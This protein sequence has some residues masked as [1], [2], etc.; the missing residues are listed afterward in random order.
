MPDADPL[1]PL[2]RL[3]GVPSAFAAARDGIDALLR[4]RGLRRTSSDQTA[5]ALLV[6][7]H[8]SAVLEG[9]TSTLDE[10]RAGTG[11]DL[12][13]DAVRVSV[14]LLSLVP[15]LRT[16]PL[17]A[18]ARLHALASGGAESGRPARRRVPG[19]PAGPRPAAGR[20]DRGAS[21]ARGGRG[22][23]RPRDG[24]ALPVPQRHRRPGRRA[25]G[26]GSPAA[27]TSA[28]CWCRK[29]GTSR[30]GRRTSRTC[31]GTAT[32][33]RP[34]WLLAEVRSR[35]GRQGGRGEPAG[36][37]L[38]EPGHRP[39]NGANGTGKRTCSARGIRSLKER[40][41][42]TDTRKPM[43]TKRAHS[44]AAS[45]RSRWLAP[46]RKGRSP[47]GYPV[48]VLVFCSSPSVVRRSREAH[49]P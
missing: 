49:K 40:G 31:A 8:A 20:H 36:A 39:S 44:T 24:G 48:R 17:Q 29:P 13:E 16:S 4:D 43:A 25:A 11:D 33:A 19:P 18:F 14:H 12:A 21:A 22:P 5:E 26:A 2:L 30:C 34:A 45:G 23:R 38:T 6:G 10:V 3:E 47:R 9:S 1:A 27:S 28:R 37:A 42:V 46:C 7:A 41:A 15:T 35:G 32:V